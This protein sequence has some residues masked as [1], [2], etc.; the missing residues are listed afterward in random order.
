MRSREELEKK[1]SEVGGEGRTPTTVLVSAAWSF[2]RREENGKKYQ[3]SA[4]RNRQSWR[5]MPM[6]P[7]ALACDSNW[8]Q[9]GGGLVLGCH[10]I[11]RSSQA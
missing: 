11:S 9:R 3:S 6:I 5:E 2:P 4:H 10:S 8:P 7:A 1:G